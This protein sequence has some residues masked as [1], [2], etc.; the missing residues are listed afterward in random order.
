MYATLFPYPTIFLST[1]CPRGPTLAT[2]PRPRGTGP[3]RCWSNHGQIMVKSWPN[4]GQIMVKSWSN[5]GQIMAK[6]WSNHGQIMVESARPRGTGPARCC[7]SLDHCGQIMAKSWPQIMVKSWWSNQT[8]VKPERPPGI[9]PARR[10][11]PL[12]HGGGRITAESRPN[13]VRITVESRSNHGRMRVLGQAGM[14][15]IEQRG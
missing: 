5:H 9:A 13:H 3:G 15:G 12:D 4:H 11:K 7:Q 1:G 10:G 2:R 6:S 14:T 8:L